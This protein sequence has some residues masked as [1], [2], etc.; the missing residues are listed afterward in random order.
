MIFCARHSARYFYKHH[1]LR[2]LQQFFQVG[3]V[4]PL[5]TGEECEAQ[6]DVYLVQSPTQPT[7]G[8]VG[9]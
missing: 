1:L 6:R 2:L 7:N 5:F 8:R 4:I 9:S 3:S